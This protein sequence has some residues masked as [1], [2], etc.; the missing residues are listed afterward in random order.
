MI[1]VDPSEVAVGDI[2]VIKA[3]RKVPLDGVVLE[4]NS[5]LD[6]AALT[7]ESLPREIEPGDDVIS[8]CINQSG[9]LRV[10]VTKVFGEST[11][12]KILNLVE[13]SSSKKAKAEN[14]I[15]KFARYYTPCV[16]IGALLLAVLP[17]LFFGG[18][19]ERLGTPCTHFPCYFLSLCACD[20][21]PA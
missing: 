4:G 15:T 1:Q 18:R 10:R 21:R 13:N 20:F 17:P 3:G 11:V 7:G 16:V 5:S 14:F 19:M 6:T 8:G 2:I 12:A 9:L